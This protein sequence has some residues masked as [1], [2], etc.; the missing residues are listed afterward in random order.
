MA[1]IEFG[2]KLER[3]DS[4]GGQPSQREGSYRGNSFDTKY[5]K[6]VLIM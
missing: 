2:L 5:R 4:A 1:H 3:V 6:P